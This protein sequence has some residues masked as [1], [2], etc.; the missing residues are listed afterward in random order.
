MVVEFGN[1]RYQQLVDRFVAGERVPERSLQRV[2]SLTIRQSGEELR[3][4]RTM[5]VGAEKAV[6]TFIFNLS[7]AEN[8]NHMGP[9]A[10]RSTAAWKEDRLII[11]STYFNAGAQVGN[12]VEA[13]ALRDG[14]LVIEEERVV[15]AGPFSRRQVYSKGS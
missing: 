10:A 12:G 4:E 3:V 15:P 5:S 8:I 13:Y 7:G 14:K 9:I 6:Y 2:V 11:T 1:A